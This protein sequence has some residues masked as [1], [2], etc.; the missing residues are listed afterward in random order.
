MRK[1]VR[2]AGK[3]V[4]ILALTY[5]LPKFV[6]FYVVCGL[7]DV[8]R[9]SAWSSELLEKYFLGNG[10]LTWL[11]S[12]INALL[13]LLSLPYVNK[14]VYALEDLPAG[15]QA[16][17]VKLIESTRKQDLVAQLQKAA[18]AESRSMFFFKWYGTNVDTIVRVPEFHDHYKHIMTIGVSIFNKRQSTS[19]H[20]GPLRASLRVLY[21]IDDV[22]D[23]SA[24]IVAGNKTSYWRENK[25]FIFDDTL[26]HQSCNETDKPRS[27]LFV[28]MVRPTTMPGV[29]KA[30]I[31]AVGL[32]MSQGSNKVFYGH[33]K[34]FRNTTAT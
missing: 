27:C 2:Q 12:P 7:Y 11:L 33:W 26:F 6:L 13:D 25:L 5:F 30:F 8:S 29:F 14:G 24:Y 9:N 23:N 34:V 19:K 4:L 1:F 3:V 28:D 20:F 17:I 32:L 10:L 31:R 22:V 15:H 21:N 16:E 18:S